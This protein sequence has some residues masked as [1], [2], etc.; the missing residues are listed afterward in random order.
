MQRLIDG[1]GQDAEAGGITW[2]R[3][4]EVRAPDMLDGLQWFFMWL[5]GEEW[6][7]EGEQK[8]VF[9]AV[10]NYQLYLPSLEKE[11]SQV[12]GIKKHKQISRLYY[13]FFFPFPDLKMHIHPTPN[14]KMLNSQHFDPARFT[15]QR[16][17]FQLQFML[18]LQ[19]SQLNFSQTK[20]FLSRKISV[21]IFR[22]YCYNLVI[23]SWIDFSSW[24]Y[25]ICLLLCEKPSPKFRGLK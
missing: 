21:L 15:L 4:R 5:E 14:P 8:H 3:K 22:R 12:P 17:S 24:P 10:Q 7:L 11:S 1:W 25:F 16:Q 20:D 13:D 9:S 19:L 18:R 23:C 6:D 2:T